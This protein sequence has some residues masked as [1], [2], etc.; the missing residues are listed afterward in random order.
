MTAV[1]RYKQLSDLGQRIEIY[2]PF[3]WSLKLQH[4]A[5]TIES[6]REIALLRSRG[7]TKFHLSFCEGGLPVVSI[8][9]L[10]L[11]QGTELPSWGDTGADAAMQQPQDADNH[12]MLITTGAAAAEK[13][14]PKMLQHINLF[15]LYYYDHI[16]KGT[17]RNV[18]N[19][20]KDLINKRRLLK[21][22]KQHI[23]AYVFS[24]LILTYFK[25]YSQL[26][27]GQHTF[28]CVFGS[29]GNEAFE[30][31]RKWVFPLQNT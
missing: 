25:A 11:I 24:S 1:F 6:R 13:D 17:I 30:R 16:D 14:W 8:V 4:V 15:T 27:T 23:F 5:R 18:H 2:S 22:L 19:L 29:K 20:N 3:G 31:K 12:R 28:S 21:Q 7:G 10:L 26:L 9:A